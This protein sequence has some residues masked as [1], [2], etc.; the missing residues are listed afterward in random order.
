MY[1][2]D[3]ESIG[4]KEI[5]SQPTGKS[6]GQN[7]LLPQQIIKPISSNKPRKEKIIT[8]LISSQE[9]KQIQ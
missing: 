1:A 6:S 9:C 2:K 7:V 4:T 8:I 3:K 5:N